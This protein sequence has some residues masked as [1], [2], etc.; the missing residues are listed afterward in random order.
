VNRPQT[1]LSVSKEDILAFIARQ[2][3]H[4]VGT[5]EIARA[6]GLKNAERAALRTLLKELAQDGQ[7]QWGGSK[8][9]AGA[10]QRAGTLPRVVLVDISGRD[11]DGELIAEPT[12]WDEEAHGAPPKIRVPT[13]RRAKPSETAGVG[14]RALLRIE[15]SR[16]ADDPIR[17]SGRVIKIID[18]AKARML[19]IFRKLPDGGGRLA[20]IDKKL[21]GREFAVPPGATGDAQEIGR[22]HV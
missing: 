16:D 11:R 15:E 10:L 12:E 5:R 22:A 8:R 4:K 6:F 21:V 20:P 18:R 7:V 13:S 9:R 19:G 17:H 1:P 3:A 2:P 14:D